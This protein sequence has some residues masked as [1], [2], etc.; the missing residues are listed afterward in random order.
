MIEILGAHEKIV[1]RSIQLPLYLGPI[2]T[3]GTLNGNSYIEVNVYHWSQVLIIVGRKLIFLFS[4]SAC[5]R[6][7]STRIVQL[8]RH[9]LFVRFL[10]V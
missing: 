5:V 9:V 8:I 4:I 6:S 7:N 10:F 2:L 3:R 1:L